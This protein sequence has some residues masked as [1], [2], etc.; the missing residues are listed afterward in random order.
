MDGGTGKVSARAER[1][2]RLPT[3]ADWHA[4]SQVFGRKYSN[5]RIGSGIG[6][7]RNINLFGSLLQFEGQVGDKG[8]RGIRGIQERRTQGKVKRGLRATSLRLLTQQNKSCK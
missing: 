7:S 8:D 4:P 6:G 5:R 3:A 2:A 1:W